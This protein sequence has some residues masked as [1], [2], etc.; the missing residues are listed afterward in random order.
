MVCLLCFMLGSMCLLVDYN[1]LSTRI[2]DGALIIL[3]SLMVFTL[4]GPSSYWDN[5]SD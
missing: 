4:K 3:C 1:H 2:W 5:D